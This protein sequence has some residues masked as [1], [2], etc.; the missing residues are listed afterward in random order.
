MDRSA[1]TLALSTALALTL[2]LALAASAPAHVTVQPS[3]L[4]AGEFVRADVR[5]PNER[6]DAS[7]TKLQLQFPSG[8]YSAS[9]QPVP[10]FSGKVKTQKL[11]K[12]LPPSEPGE[13]Q[14]TE[15]VREVTFTATG[16]GIGPDQFQDFGLSLLMPKKE[17]TTLTFKAIQTY[18][19]GKV[20]RWIGPPDSE[21]PAPQVKL[22]SAEDGAA[23]PAAATGSSGGDD[24]DA[25]KGLGIAALILGG[26]GLL[27][28]LAALARGA[29]RPERT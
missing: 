17:G 7:T 22:T 18:D 1:R 11:S 25:S 24:N 19:D 8:F 29:R 15:Q 26:L 5:V 16:K 21:E 6:G 13:E 12:P 2:G 3:E 20:V 28:G 10:G 9:Y 27:I 4:P 14:I 23:A